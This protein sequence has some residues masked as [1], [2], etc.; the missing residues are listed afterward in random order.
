MIGLQHA[1]G[2]V[3]QALSQESQLD[4]QLIQ[5][6]MSE[7]PARVAG[8]TD[9]G[10]IKI[11]KRADL[12]AIDP[13]RFEIVHLDNSQSLSANN[14]YLGMNLPNPVVHVWTGGRQLVSEGTMHG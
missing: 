5:R 4:W 9:R 2:A 3:Q 1:L 10:A 14:P 13:T 12:L 7:Q 11:G 8:L 6:V